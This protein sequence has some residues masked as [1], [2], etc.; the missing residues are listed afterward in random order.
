MNPRYRDLIK[1]SGIYGIGQ[2]LGRLTSI[3]MLPV[4][5]RYLTPT[6]YGTI[7]ILDLTLGLLGIL[8]GGGISSALVRYHQ[9]ATTSEGESAVWWTGLTVVAALTA[10]IILP[11]AIFR[12]AFA[13]LTL[14]AQEPSGA[15]FFGL[16]LATLWFS[17]LSQVA[18][19]YFRLRMWS[20]LNVGLALASLFFNIGLNVYLL[21]VRGWGITAILVGNLVTLTIFSVIRLTIV[22]RSCGRFNFDAPLAWRLLRFGAPIV[23]TLL[24]ATV[25]HQADRYLLRRFLDLETVGVYS[26]A[27][28][29]G[30]GINSLFLIP[31]AAVWSVSLYDIAKQPDARVAFARIFEYFVYGVL[32]LMLGVSLFVEPL[33]E[34][35][36]TDAYAGAAALVPIV[37]LS[38]VFF[39]ADEHFRVPALLAKRTLSLVPANALGATANVLLNLLLIPIYGVVAAAWVSVATYAIFAGVNLLQARRIDRYDYP[40]GRCAAIL[41]AMVVSVVVSRRL[42]T[43]FQSVAWSLAV[44]LVIWCGWAAALTYPFLKH[45][46]RV[47]VAEAGL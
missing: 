31:F 40:L 21:V 22:S 46:R 19:A 33:L 26:L 29:M 18:T 4:H 47:R 44:P 27:Y 41:V 45:Y 35:V 16:M 2:L 9:E 5:T 24:L 6:D 36:A 12:D 17:V 13:D 20:W 30:Q 34:L 43:A 25:M 32:L 14:G 10:A 28:Q 8:V 37:C 42:E 23:A 15:F 3:V 1:H 11:A 38:L 7:A 39:S